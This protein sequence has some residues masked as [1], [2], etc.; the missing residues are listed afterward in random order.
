M[1]KFIAALTLTTLSFSSFAANLDTV[2]LVLQGIVAEVLEISIAPTAAASNLDLSQA[3]TNVPVAVLTEK[4]NHPV[5]YKIRSKSVQGAK[6]VNASDANSF[7]SYS[8]TYNGTQIPL[9]TGFADISGSTNNQRGTFTRDI[10]ISYGA[11]SNLSAGTYSD[12]VTFQ[13]MAN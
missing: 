4:S 2:N 9:G 11:P 6:L 7:V 3:A 13:I 1:K 5:G 8:I 12:T 10:K